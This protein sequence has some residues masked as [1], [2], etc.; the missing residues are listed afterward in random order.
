M[1]PPV[2][3]AILWRSKQ[4]SSGEWASERWCAVAWGLGTSSPSAF[5][6]WW[7]HRDTCRKCTRTLRLRKPAG[8]T[9]TGHQTCDTP[10]VHSNSHNG[11]RKY[12]R[13]SLFSEKRH[14]GLGG[15]LPGQGRPSGKDSAVVRESAMLEISCAFC[16]LNAGAFLQ[17]C[18]HCRGL[19]TL[20]ETQKHSR[21][22]TVQ[23]TGLQFS[24]SQPSYGF[25]P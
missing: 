2:S 8:N 15:W 20:V 3:P 17:N 1:Q 16:L 23:E 11:P 13:L 7:A 22:K 10:Y 14:L 18:L 4:N 21:W 25:N 5:N 19:L 12:L 6:I 9:T 24:G